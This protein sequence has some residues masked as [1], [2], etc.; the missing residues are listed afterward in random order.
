MVLKLVVRR[1]HR[2]IQIYSCMYARCVYFGVII[3]T[4]IST[5]F[6]H[7]IPS[8]ILEPSGQKNHLEQI[9]SY[10]FETNVL[11]L[12]SHPPA[13]SPPSSLHDPPQHRT[14][15]QLPRFM[16]EGETSTQ[17][18]PAQFSRTKFAQIRVPT[19]NSASSAATV[20]SLSKS[21]SP[22]RT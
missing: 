8:C 15:E 9:I 22:L 6:L 17:P 7:T 3:G 12:Q 16:A 14:L 1:N 19:A 13:R 21:T 18:K 11:R 10:K 5:Y 20:N 2:F 4:V